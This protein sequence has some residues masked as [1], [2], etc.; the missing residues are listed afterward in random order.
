MRDERRSG[1]LFHA[2][3]TVPRE[4]ETLYELE[5]ETDHMFLCRRPQGSQ[6]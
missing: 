6:M 5:A 1:R 3:K 2:G 4:L